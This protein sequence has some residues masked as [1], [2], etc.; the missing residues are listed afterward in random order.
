MQYMNEKHG[1]I[2]TSHTSHLQH[3]P[4]QKQEYG[5]SASRNY[6]HVRCVCDGRGYDAADVHDAPS[7]EECGGD[8]L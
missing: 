8:G 4:K 7:K 2:V 1:A 3:M 6:Q 5:T